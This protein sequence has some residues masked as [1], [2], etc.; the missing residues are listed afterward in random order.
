MRRKLAASPG[1]AGSLRAHGGLGPLYAVWKTKGWS[2]GTL[3]CTDTKHTN[4]C[5]TGY[6]YA[7][8]YGAFSTRE[9]VQR[10]LVHP[11]IQLFCN[12]PHKARHETSLQ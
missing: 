6:S 9:L 10:V 1:L 2:W 12:E 7:E 11:D 5:M 8:K 4:H 3:S